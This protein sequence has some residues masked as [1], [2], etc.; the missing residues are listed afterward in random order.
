M[1]RSLHTSSS[2]RYVKSAVNI[3]NK[4][5][6]LSKSRKVIWHIVGMPEYLL[7]V[8]LHLI[9]QNN[10]VSGSD[11][12][13]N[14]QHYT[15]FGRLFKSFGRP[16]YLKWKA[17][18][19]ILYSDD[20]VKDFYRKNYRIQSLNVNS[21]HY[22]NHKSPVK[23]IESLSMKIYFFIGA[24]EVDSP[25]KFL[26]TGLVSTTNTQIISLYQPYQTKNKFFKNESFL[27]C[28][29]KQTNLNVQ[30]LCWENVSHYSF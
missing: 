28:R 6:K 15:A 2:V 8:Y 24:C 16:N 27:L 9:N 20:L 12:G 5:V 18:H 11:Y 30:D 10:P 25:C 19:T 14:Q 22:S 13:Q 29:L 7:E 26:L 1:F 17:K 23:Y 4:Q 21:G 3:Q